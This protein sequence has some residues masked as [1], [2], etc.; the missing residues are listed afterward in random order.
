MPWH[1]KKKTTLKCKQHTF[2]VILKKQQCFKEK[3]CISFTF[4][5]LS[6]FKYCLLLVRNSIAN[7]N[8]PG[9]RAG[10]EEG[11]SLKHF[12]PW[13]ENLEGCC[14]SNLY[15]A[16]QVIRCLCCKSAMILVPQIYVVTIVGTS[17]KSCKS[18]E[19]RGVHFLLNVLSNYRHYKSF[20]AYEESR[21][22]KEH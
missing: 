18:K 2:Y 8:F 17:F 21:K 19:R 12:F 5:V 1:K 4:Y 16:Q 15:Q 9:W 14:L 13:E 11:H 3:S 6:M 7:R 10:A 20:T 22:E